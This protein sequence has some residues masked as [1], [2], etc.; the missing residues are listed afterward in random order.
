MHLIHTITT[1]LAGSIQVGALTVSVR[2]LLMSVITIAMV[3]VALTLPFPRGEGAIA[4]R[5]TAAPPAP[6]DDPERAAGARVR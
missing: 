1:D 6:Q 5:R 2:T 4:A 3:M